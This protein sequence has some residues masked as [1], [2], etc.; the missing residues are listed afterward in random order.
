MSGFELSFGVLVLNALES[1]RLSRNLVLLLSTF[2]CFLVFSFDGSV[3]GFGTFGIRIW[4]EGLSR[5]LLAE[6]GVVRWF[7]PSAVCESK[8]AD[9]DTFVQA[10][11]TP[12]WI[13]RA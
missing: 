7:C 6:S 8:P 2:C 11:D 9:D 13:H 1:P 5:L 10:C 3:F 4:F 12:W